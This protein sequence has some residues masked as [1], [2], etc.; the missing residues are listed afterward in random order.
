MDH[1]P[2][3]IRDDPRALMQLLLEGEFTLDGEDTPS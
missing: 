2:F 3:W 1:L